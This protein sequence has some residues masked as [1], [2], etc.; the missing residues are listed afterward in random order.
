MKTRDFDA[1][2]RNNSS[3]PVMRREDRRRGGGRRNDGMSAGTALMGA[4]CVAGVFGVLALL[5][6]LG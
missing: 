1:L 3:P 4:V 6:Y 5:Y 2:P